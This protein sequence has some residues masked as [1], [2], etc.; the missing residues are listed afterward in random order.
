[1]TIVGV[2]ALAS[3]HAAE[4]KRLSELAGTLAR[5]GLRALGGVW[6]TSPEKVLTVDW[7]PMVDAFVAQR[8][9]LWL[10]LADAKTLADPAHR[11][12]LNL[13]A[14]NLR[15]AL[16]PN[17]PMVVLRVDAAGTVLPARPALPAQ[18]RNALVLKAGD[19]WPAR[20]VAYMHRTHAVAGQ[21]PDRLSVHGNAQIGQWIELTPGAGSWQGV[22]FAVSGEG[23][24]IDFQAI[25]P[26]G[27]LPETSAIAYGQSGLKLESA[28]RSFTGWA[29]R[30]T[31]GALVAGPVSSVSSISYYARVRGRPEALLWMPYSEDDDANAT[32]FALD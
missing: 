10:V 6:E 15:S 25:G 11:Y 17:F 32:L 28:G 9:A 1:M 30:N 7:R 31:V 2:T 29:L 20:L 21:A 23:A 3:G 27:G 4:E 8:A 22:M 13:I 16:G 12:G 19:A 18:L 14:A 24:S 26:G 5:Y